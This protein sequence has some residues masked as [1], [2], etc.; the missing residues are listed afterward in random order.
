MPVQPRKAMCSNACADPGKPAGVS[1]PPTLKFS[2]TVT[3]GASSLR[4]MT[5]CKPLGRV[6]RVTLLGSA[7]YSCAVS[8]NSKGSRVLTFNWP[9]PQF[10]GR[11]DLYSDR[12]LDA[13]SLVWHAWPSATI[14]V[15]TLRAGHQRLLSGC[16]WLRQ[17][18]HH[19]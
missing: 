8:R 17:A 5:T 12:H 10:P 14:E 4:T 9:S 16:V 3:T 11:Q 19:G 7:A 18:E 1:S 15:L 2:S 6:A 13:P